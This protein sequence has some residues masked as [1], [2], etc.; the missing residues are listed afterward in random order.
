MIYQLLPYDVHFHFVQKVEPKT[1]VSTGLEF[2]PFKQ[3]KIKILP[4]T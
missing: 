3:N 4:L 1:Y 2:F